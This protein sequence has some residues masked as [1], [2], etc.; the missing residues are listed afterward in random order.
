[1]N[2]ALVLSLKNKNFYK[3]KKILF[4]G[5][6]VLENEKPQKFNYNIFIS[7]SGSKEYRKKNCLSSDR[8]YQNLILDLSKELNLFHSINLDLKSWKIIFGNW[9]R[10]FVDICYERDF[11]INEIIK[12]H[13]IS[14]I[15]GIKN[16]NFK[17]FTDDSFGI[18]YKASDNDWNNNLFYKIINYY[19]FP[20][21]QNFITAD[22]EKNENYQEQF[23]V[24]EKKRVTYVKKFLNNLKFFKKNND[25][26]ITQTYLPLFYEKLFELSFFQISPIFKPKKIFYKTYDARLRL[27]IKLPHTSEKNIDNFIRE[28]LV[29]FL[30]ICFVESFQ[31]IFQNCEKDFPKNPKF[32]MTAISYDFDENFKFYTAKKVNDKVPYFVLQHG[33]TYL[34]EDLVFNRTEYET[35]TKF[36]TFGYS[37]KKFTEKFCNQITLRNPVKYDKD[38]FLHAICPPVQNRSFPYDR[39]QEWLARLKLIKQ[40]G[41]KID[42]KLKEKLI[43]RIHPDYLK[44][45]R[46]KWHLNKY[47][48]NF[49]KDHVDY[50]ERDYFRN[51][52]DSRLNLFFY[53]STGLLENLIYNI[54]SV[55]I[56][57]NPY[58]HIADEFVDKYK[59]LMDANIL[60]DDVEKLLIHINHNWENIDA[61][62]FS[63]K[64]Q[65]NISDFNK[66]LNKKGSLHSLLKLR[67]FI[68]KYL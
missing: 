53:D 61:W 52:K 41:D 32:I 33:N 28:N 29:N 58:N 6:W 34:V 50:G 39:D 23:E 15:Y 20:T 26:L 1:M 56:L 24:K 40:F 14:S 65:K 46:G 27:K 30:P 8:I 4:A 7:K 31:N 25:A 13:K 10:Y 3:E 54:P 9:L 17:F 63:Q 42:N 59:I 38:G 5:E 11:L 68:K 22:F 62:W 47:F 19:K 67:K 66:N 43:L 21:N 44:S 49:D 12:S 36:L 16:E 48:Q 60:F 64:T 37:N 18:F 35:S 51:L 55:M 57:S 2:Q 45:K